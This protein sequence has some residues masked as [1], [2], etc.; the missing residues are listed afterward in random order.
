MNNIDIKLQIIVSAAF[1]LQGRRSEMSKQIK[2]R[3][4]DYKS[5]KERIKEL[6]DELEK[7]VADV[8]ESESY[9]AFLECCAKF[10]SYSINNC[11]LIMAQYPSASRVAGYTDWQKKFG[12][13]VKKGAKGIKILAP[14]KYKVEI[15]DREGSDQG[16][17]A[18]D[19]GK[20]TIERLGF[21]VVTVF[22]VSMTEGKELPSI[23][24]DEL[25]G[26]VK[27]YR[28]IFNALVSISPVPVFFED[29]EGGA[30]GYYNDAEK[31]IAIKSEMSEAQT[32]KTLL[33]EISHAVYHSKEALEEHDQL[34]RRHKETEAESIA[35]IVGKALDIVDSSEYSYPYLASWASG[36]D[37]KELKGSLER[38]RSAADEMITGI[39]TALER[40]TK[41]EQTKAAREEVR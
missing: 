27:D 36:K 1:I 12:R 39:E 35:H 3:S 40:Q 34:D 9:K 2:A 17:A 18:E 5:Q 32:V 33:H 23:G 4:P 8:F 14:C 38:I 6:T 24:V 21:K 28:K 26:D 16:I 25:T 11:I 20:K 7:G 29:I 31:R 19:A 10:H 22:D 30:K 15:E 41:R 37:I 13:H